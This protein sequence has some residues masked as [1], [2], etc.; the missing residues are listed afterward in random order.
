MIECVLTPRRALGEYT[1]TVGEE[2]I[3]ELRELA[4]PLCGARVLHLNATAAGGGVA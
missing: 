2:C 3:Q 4:K 1:S